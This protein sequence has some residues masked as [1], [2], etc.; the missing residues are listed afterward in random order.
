MELGSSSPTT[1]VSAEM[2]TLSD[3]DIRVQL[4]LN[5]HPAGSGGE[6]LGR[7]A[8]R[9][10]PAAACCEQLTH[11]VVTS[12]GTPSIRCILAP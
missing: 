10:D 4:R 1:V 8:Q 2:S 9:R 6:P 5:S 11:P 7:G 3:H 12:P